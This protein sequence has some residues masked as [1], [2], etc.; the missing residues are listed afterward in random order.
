MGQKPMLTITETTEQSTNRFRRIEWITILE[1]FGV[2]LFLLLLVVFFQLQNERFLSIRNILNILS[3]VSI[4]GILSVGMTFVILTSGIDLSIGSLLA[5][6]SMCGAVTVKSWPNISATGLTWLIAPIIALTI[7]AA[8]GYLHGK[9]ITKLRVPAFIVTL[10]GMTLWRGATLMLSNG[11]PISGFDTSYRWWGRGDILGFPFLVLISAVVAGIGFVVLRYTRFG[12]HVYAV[13]DNPEAARLSGLNVDGVLIRVYAI[14]GCL[15][16]LAGFILSARLSSAEAVAGEGYELRVIASVVI[17]GTSLFGGLGGIAGT[18][19]GT[20]LIGVLLNG[21]VIMN[22]S[23]YS[24]QV[25]IGI[26][27]VLA[28]AFDTFTKTR[29]GRAIGK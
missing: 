3:D 8:A 16:G 11:S 23:A 17:G 5:F 10:G 26:I 14:M 2:V 28:V 20:L 18:I 6:A 22:V 1:K 29:R 25:I 27:I 15:A 7:G 9:A 12:R 21:L 24:Q 19:V 4:Y 13:G